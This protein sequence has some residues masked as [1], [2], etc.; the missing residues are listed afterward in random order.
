MELA[1]LAVLGESASAAN[2]NLTGDPLLARDFRDLLDLALPDWEEEIARL[3][4]DVPAR[5]IARALR[6]LGQ[7]AGDTGDRLGADLADYLKEEHRS[8]PSR[9]EVDE[10]LDG[11]DSLTG[12]ADR[13]E[14]RL[15]RLERNRG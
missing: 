6:G 15:R 2:L 3:T 9:W 5:Q 4:G 12:D 1:R 8:L 10:F 7:W 14:A 11:V 13:L